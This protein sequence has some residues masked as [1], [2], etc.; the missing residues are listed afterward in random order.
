[1]FP[2]DASDGT[3]LGFRQLASKSKGQLL[4]KILQ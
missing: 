4:Q 1:M 2:A 3:C